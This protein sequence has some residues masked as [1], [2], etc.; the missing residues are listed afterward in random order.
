MMIDYHVTIGDLVTW[1][2]DQIND[3]SIEVGVVVSLEARGDDDCRMSGAWVKWA[4][5]ATGW[6]PME[7]LVAL[8]AEH[9]AVAE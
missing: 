9:I 8:P 6:S 5:N 4:C 1:R 3:D 2:A 7:F